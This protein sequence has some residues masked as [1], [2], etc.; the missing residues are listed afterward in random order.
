[1]FVDE[2]FGECQRAD[3]GFRSRI[4]AGI[5]DMFT[6]LFAHFLIPPFVDG[7]SYFYIPT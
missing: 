1:M 5:S 4:R 6:L 3:I 2:G 7:Y